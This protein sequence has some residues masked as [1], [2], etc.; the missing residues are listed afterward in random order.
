MRSSQSTTSPRR[1]TLSDSRNTK[2]AGSS[3]Q[4]TTPDEWEYDDEVQD[5]VEVDTALDNEEDLMEVQN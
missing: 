4:G 3:K 1:T 5:V 2:H